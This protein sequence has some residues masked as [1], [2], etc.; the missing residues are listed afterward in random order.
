MLGVLTGRIALILFVLAGLH[1]QNIA[2]LL[3]WSRIKQRTTTPYG[4]VMTRPDKKQQP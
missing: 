4:R 2:V 3:I 1:Y